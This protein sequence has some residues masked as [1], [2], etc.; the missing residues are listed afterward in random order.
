MK[1]AASSVLPEPPSRATA[2]Y[3]N[4][5]RVRVTMPLVTREATIFP[6]QD[7]ALDPGHQRG[8]DV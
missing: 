7:A 4:T 3:G 2:G 5:G 1:F 8:E 6:G